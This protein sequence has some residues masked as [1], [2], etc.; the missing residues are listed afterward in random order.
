MILDPKILSAFCAILL[1]LIA[2]IPYLVTIFR[3]TNKPHLFS[4]V[5]WM[6][7]TAVVVAA[8]ITGSAGWATLVTATTFFL[9]AAISWLAFR[10]GEKHI[11]R[12][13]WVMLVASLSAIPV[14]IMT[15]DPF[16]S[17]V[18]VTAINAAAYVPTFRKAWHKP[19]E[20]HILMYAINIPRHMLTIVATGVYSWTNVM[21]PASVVLACIVLFGGIQYRRV[22]LGRTP[23]ADQIPPG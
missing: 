7:V 10:Q 5:I 21:Y 22:T 1:V 20:E 19:F 15:S 2:Y 4:W 8:Q 11:T 23:D 16:W 14:W 13:D 3:G 6:L 9:C 12:S 17:V 18:I